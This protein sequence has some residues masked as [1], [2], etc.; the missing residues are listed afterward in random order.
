MVA[1]GMMEMAINEVVNVITVR[2][3]LV[4]APWTMYMICV[5]PATLVRGS[6]A[7]RIGIGYLQ[8]ML[9]DF[10]VFTDVMQ[11][12]VVQVV[13]MVTMLNSSMLTVRS[14]LV[15]MVRMCITHLRFLW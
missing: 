12:T 1:V 11:M 10:S 9:F 8:R 4:T 14:V 13:D 15:V 5:M 7:A 6:A 3:R 2:Y